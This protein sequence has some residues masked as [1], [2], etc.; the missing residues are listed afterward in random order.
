MTKKRIF[1]KRTEA[2]KKAWRTRRSKAKKRSEAAKK[3]WRTRR[4][5]AKKR[6]EAAKKAA[7]TRKRNAAKRS[8]ATKSKTKRKS[9]TKISNAAKIVSR[10]GGKGAGVIYALS[11]PSWPGWIKIGMSVTG[12]SIESR[13]NTSYPYRDAKLIEEVRVS[14]RSKAERRIHKLVEEKS[15]ARKN[16]WFRISQKEVRRFMRVVGNEF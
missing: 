3:A 10:R 14:S 16:E 2:A 11:N 6:S 8:N 9:T 15:K 5:K 12:L 13:Y 4:S 7:A 1:S